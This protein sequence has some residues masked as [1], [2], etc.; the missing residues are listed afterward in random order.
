MP[1]ARRP[2]TFPQPHSRRPLPTCSGDPLAAALIATHP[3][4]PAHVIAR[5]VPHRVETIRT[6]AVSAL[7]DPGDIDQAVRAGGVSELKGAEADPRTDPALLEV[8]TRHTS[9]GVRPKAWRNP[10]TPGRARAWARGPRSCATT[11]RA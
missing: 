2:T 4:P 7:A 10:A 5:L 8:A 3:A 11:G 6:A 1:A 9:R